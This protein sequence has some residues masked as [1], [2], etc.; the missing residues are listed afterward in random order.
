MAVENHAPADPFYLPQS[1]G[2]RPFFTVLP[3]FLRVKL[4]L[5]SFDRASLTLLFRFFGHY[6]V[7]INSASQSFG[8]AQIPFDC[9]NRLGSL[10]RCGAKSNY[11]ATYPLRPDEYAGHIACDYP[12]RACYF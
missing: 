9:F 5:K 10:V 11:Y 12:Y 3:P 1:L 8:Y 2:L 4:I 6:F 7:Q